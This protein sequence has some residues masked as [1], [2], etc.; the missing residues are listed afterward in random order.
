MWISNN[1]S[2]YPLNQQNYSFSYDH[3]KNNPNDIN[4][5]P[6]YQTPVKEMSNIPINNN[7][8]SNIFNFNNTFGYLWSSGH[9]PQMDNTPNPEQNLENIFQKPAEHSSSKQSPDSELQL[10]GNYNNYPVNGFNNKSNESKGGNVK[11]RNSSLSRRNLTEVFNNIKGE[12]FLNQ[13]KERE[14]N[15]RGYIRNNNGGGLVIQRVNQPIIVPISSIKNNTFDLSNNSNIIITTNIREKIKQEIKKVNNKPSIEHYEDKVNI[16]NKKNSNNENKISFESPTKR[17][18]RKKIFECSGS[19]LPTGNSNK[20]LNKKRRLRKNNDQIIKLRKFYDE[21]KQWSKNEIKEM[22]N[23][24]GLQENKV[25]KW[26]WDQKNK[27][28]K[29]TRFVV[30]SKNP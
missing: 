3:I 6:L 30:V 22:G 7:P 20:L 1:T 17:T 15:I 18:K 2:S 25:Y 23:T 13:K 27:E 5:N 26:L 8:H 19:T 4:L 9:M 28:M 24:I 14:K 16:D 21:H 29:S 11:N 10:K 12:E